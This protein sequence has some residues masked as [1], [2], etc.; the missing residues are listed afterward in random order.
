MRKDRHKISCDVT[1]ALQHM[2]QRG[3]IHGD[4]KNNNLVL[5]TR[6]SSHPKP[7]IFDIGK[8]VLAVVIRFSTAETCMIA[9][10][11]FSSFLEKVCM[12]Y[13]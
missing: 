10:G 5:E 3:Y 7:V 8:S 11:R 6:E 13:N 12:I 2:H 9:A 1:D 4:L